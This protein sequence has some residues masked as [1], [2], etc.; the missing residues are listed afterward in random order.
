MIPMAK[1]IA[2]GAKFGV[3]LYAAGEAA[4]AKQQEDMRTAAI[5]AQARKVA[6]NRDTQ[7]FLKNQQD[8][9]DQNTSDNFNISL[10][11]AQAQDELALS[12]AGS[13]L[14]GASIDEL[15]DEI[16]REVS[17]DRVAADRAMR[18]AS[19]A[20]RIN[21][22]QENENRVYEAENMYVHNYAKDLEGDFLRAVGSAM[23]I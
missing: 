13:G 6:S 7:A 10:A 23:D 20:A 11:Q 16:T 5:A 3:D 17:R 8:L 14:A 21:L 2:K 19:D 22:K 18:S 15:G 4:K 1:M 9:K 12:T